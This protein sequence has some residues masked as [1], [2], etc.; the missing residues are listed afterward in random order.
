MVSGFHGNTDP[1]FVMFCLLA[2]LLALNRW[3]AA[4]GVSLG[5]AVSVKLIPLVL[6]PLMIVL[7]WRQGRD[8]LLRFAAGG[9]VTFALLWGP[10]LLLNWSAFSEQVLGY[11]GISLREWGV[12]QFLTW[13]HASPALVDTYV[14]KGRLL[15][16]AV[17][18]LVPAVL[19]WR[20]RAAAQ[21]ATTFALALFL[22][23]SPAFGM[24][25]LVWPLAASL[26]LLR[27]WP[28][29][30]YHLSAG[31]F[32]LVVYS[33]W[34]HGPPWA[35]GRAHATANTADVDF[36]LMVLTWLALAAVCL[37]SLREAWT[38]SDDQSAEWTSHPTPTKG[39]RP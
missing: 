37:A 17:S 35:W 14:E 24:Q 38:I 26:L 6:F 30:T 11:Q 8:A 36:V 9:A 1:L 16:L 4:A 3:P 15:T 27:P 2:L 10:V 12:P 21:P 20:S 18:A 23:L 5:L 22:L 13:L 34:N 28:A 25:Y 19:V 32:A 29:V 33:Q 31:T 39:T 7:V